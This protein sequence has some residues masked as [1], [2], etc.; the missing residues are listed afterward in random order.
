MPQYTFSPKTS[1]ARKLHEEQRRATFK[2]LESHSA[3]NNNPI[4]TRAYSVVI[5]DC[6]YGLKKKK[7]RFD[8]SWQSEQF[9]GFFQNL[10]EANQ[11]QHYVTI[12]F[13]H[14]KQLHV[15]L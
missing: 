11:S 8:E 7:S 5:A 1:D 15:R 9:E 14:D 6:N 4:P 2:D 3:E 10:K 12:V 13:L